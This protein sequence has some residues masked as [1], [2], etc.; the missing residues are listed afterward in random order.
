MSDI[1]DDDIARYLYGGAKN[2]AK[3]Q[4][5]ISSKSDEEEPQVYPVAKAEAPKK[6]QQQRKVSFLVEEEEAE[7]EE[8]PRRSL[9]RRSSTA[10]ADAD[11]DETPDKFIQQMAKQGKQFT[12]PIGR[13]PRLSGGRKISVRAKLAARSL[14]E[15]SQELRLTSDTR[16]E[17]Q[18]LLDCP[19]DGTQIDPLVTLYTRVPTGTCVI[20][21]KETVPV[22]TLLKA[23]ALNATFTVQ[24]TGKAK[25]QPESFA[26]VSVKPCKELK[27]TLDVQTFDIEKIVTNA[28]EE[29]QHDYDEQIK[30]YMYTLGPVSS[31]EASDLEFIERHV[32]QVKDILKGKLIVL[33]ED[34]RPVARRAAVAMEEED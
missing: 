4:A 18:M 11:A 23:I 26:K 16:Q 9:K 13:N 22:S 2:G 6:Q 12:M 10:S 14:V 28:M 30:G 15:Q 25:T 5:K 32:E 7:E 3:K 21:L 19:D 33:K 27:E 29:Q 31:Y 8:K 20:Y 17:L 34:K 1:D 24:V